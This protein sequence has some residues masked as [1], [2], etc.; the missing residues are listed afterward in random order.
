MC[1]IPDRTE[2]ILF[3]EEFEDGGAECAMDFNLMAVMYQAYME[4]GQ[5]SEE[6]RSLAERRIQGLSEG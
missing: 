3:G 6:F 5:D 4:Y 1:R 2:E